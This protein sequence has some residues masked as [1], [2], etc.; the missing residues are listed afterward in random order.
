MDMDYA[1]VILAY[2]GDIDQLREA[3]AGAGLTLT[4]RGGQW[5]LARAGQ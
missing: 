5:T 4:N 1:R 3:L 2:L